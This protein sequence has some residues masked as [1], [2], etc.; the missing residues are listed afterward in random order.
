MSYTN[1]DA[2]AAAAELYRLAVA[3]EMIFACERGD[4]WTGNGNDGPSPEAY[5]K[6]EAEYPDLVAKSK[7]LRPPK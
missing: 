1:A 3:Q 4:G 2:T 5:A 7:Q 6:I